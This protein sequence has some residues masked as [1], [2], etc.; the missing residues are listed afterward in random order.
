MTTILRPEHPRPDRLR[1]NWMTLN[2]PW[3]FA[4]DEQNAGKKEKWYLQKDYPLQIQVPFAY[5][6]QLSGIK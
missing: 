5:Q 1:E 3:R 2:G 4:F 6:S